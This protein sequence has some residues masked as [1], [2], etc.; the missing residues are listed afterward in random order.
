MHVDINGRTEHL[1]PGLTIAGFLAARDL[2]PEAVVV[3][4]NGVIVDTD[5]YHETALEDN[6]RLEVLHFVGGG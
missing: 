1:N 3:E 5:R 2:D 6:D 4:L